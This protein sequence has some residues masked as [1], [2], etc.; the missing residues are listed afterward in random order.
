[1]K[2]GQSLSKMRNPTALHTEDTAQ[3][4]EWFNIP[5]IAKKLHSGTS[6]SGTVV[7]ITTKLQTGT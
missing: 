4:S 1:V 7:E 6:N 3:V 2:T 5:D